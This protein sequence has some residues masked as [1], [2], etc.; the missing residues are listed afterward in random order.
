MPRLSRQRQEAIEAIRQRFALG[1]P[2]KLRAIEKAAAL[3]QDRGPEP[4][5]IDC[6]FRDAHGLAGS[7]GIFGYKEVAEAA[8]ALETLMTEPP[9]MPAG[10]PGWKQQIA[11]AMQ[12]LRRSR[13]R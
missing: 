12:R 2:E 11:S 5:L 6:L 10:V 4:E 3:L 7:A 13:A 8:A 9:E 1:I